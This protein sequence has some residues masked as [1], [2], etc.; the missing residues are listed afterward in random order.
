M[1]GGNASGPG[2]VNLLDPVE[3]TQRIEP[4]GHEHLRS[5][6]ERRQHTRHQPV[7]VEERHDLQASVV[8]RQRERGGD[9]PRRGAQIRL[10]ERDE[11][12]ASCGSAGVQQKRDVLTLPGARR[13]R[14]STQRRGSLQP[15]GPRAL[16]RLRMQLDDGDGEL[17]RHLSRWRVHAGLDHEGLRAQVAQVEVEL[18]LA[19]ARIQRRRRDSRGEARESSGH[20]RPVAQD[21][22]DAV[23]AS[24][25]HRVDGVDGARRQLAQGVPGQR[26]RRIGRAD[27]ARSGG[28][29]RELRQNG[30]GILHGVASIT[31]A[32]PQRASVRRIRPPRSATRDR[33]GSRNGS[34]LPPR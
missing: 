15:E 22:R 19:V 2:G 26:L 3:E 32:P 10:R 28:A 8:R 12:R 5:R 34:R 17:R 23:A 31:D 9:V 4:R 14:L 7:D 20:L 30:V 29:P 25:S 24:D 16:C 11:L 27:G 13:L 21:H 6:G 33:R 1:H 18:V